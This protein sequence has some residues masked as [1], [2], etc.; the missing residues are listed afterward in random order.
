MESFN[1]IGSGI[2]PPGLREMSVIGSPGIR[3]CSRQASFLGRAH[4]ARSPPACPPIVVCGESQP[5]VRGMKFIELFIEEFWTRN[6][7]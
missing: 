7:E 3:K 4:K 5:G 1:E 2:C 6:R